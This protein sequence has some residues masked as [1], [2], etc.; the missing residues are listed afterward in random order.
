MF[1]TWWE[2]VARTALVM[3]VKVSIVHLRC[4]FGLREAARAVPK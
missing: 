2:G 4:A 3:V 1:Y